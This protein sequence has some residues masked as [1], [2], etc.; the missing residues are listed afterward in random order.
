MTEIHPPGRPGDTQSRSSEYWDLRYAGS[1]FLW[2][3]QPN[4]FLLAEVSTLDPGRALDLA[5]GEGRNAVWLAEQ[6][7]E[8]TAVDFS[9][10][11]LAKAKLLAA[12]RGV[13]ANWI[14]ADLT[15]YVPPAGAFDLVAVL[16]LQLPASE[17]RPVLR[18]AAG[19]VAPG[20]TLL[21]VGHDLA[22]LTE[23]YG[24][25]TDPDVLFTADEVAAE[26]A[27]LTVE[28]AD[29]VERPV[30]LGGGERIAIDAL[31]RAVKPLHGRS[32]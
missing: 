29:R 6:G 8:V 13:A 27:G 17:R 1:E 26:L 10:A 18:R 16:Y 4:R 24:G 9:E 22:N 7:W 3:A 30:A 14:L 15:E 32:P 20:G 31:V 5:C 2:S 12:E 28:R 11:G 23:G 19:A 25:P 21:V